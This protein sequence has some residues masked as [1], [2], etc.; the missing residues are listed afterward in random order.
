MLN[1]TTSVYTAFIKHAP[2]CT[3]LVGNYAEWVLES[4][5]D[6]SLGD[7]PKYGKVYFDWCIAGTRD[8]GLLLG[9]DGTLIDMDSHDFRI[10][11]TGAVS[12]KLITISYYR[13]AVTLPV[14]EPFHPE[15][16]F[17]RLSLSG[18]RVG[19]TRRTA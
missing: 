6:G 18:G 2:S 11:V 8:H 17:P 19:F 14:G 10:S 15:L 13:P 16:R 4:P 1:V 5:S 12:D 7:L 9:G 3:R